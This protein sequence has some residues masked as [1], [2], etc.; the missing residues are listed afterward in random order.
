MRLKAFIG[1]IGDDIPS[2]FPIVTGI[3]IF[4]MSILF[5]QQQVTE[6]NALLDVRDQVLQLSYLA[7]EKG[8]MT[9]ADFRAKCSLVRDMAKTRHLNFTMILKPFCGPVNVNDFFLVNPNDPL[10][11]PYRSTNGLCVAENNDFYSR[12]PAAHNP[13]QAMGFP[14]KNTVVMSYPMAVDCGEGKR[15]IGFL[16][17]AGWR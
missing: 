13:P 16:S 9:P 10:L 1:P 8:Y 12:W 11:V 15:G 14:T 7:T 2:I 6:R 4:L 5:I 17:I 3:L